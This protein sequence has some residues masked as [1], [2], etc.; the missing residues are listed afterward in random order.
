MTEPPEPEYD[1]GETLVVQH[2]EMAGPSALTQVLDARAATRPWRL[3]DVSAGAPFPDLD[4]VRGIVVLGGSMGVHDTADHP[5]LEGEIAG[6]RAALRRG[7][8][9][10]GICLGVQLLGAILGGEVRARGVPEIGF[11]PLERTA[12][13]RDD[14]VFAGWP[15]GA[16]TLFIHDDEVVRLPDGAVATLTGSDG[17]AAWRAPDGLSYGVQFHPEVDAAQVAAWCSEPRNRIRFE[18]AGVDPD[19]LAAEADRREPYVRA[20]GLALVGRWLDAVVGRDDP[21]PSRGRRARA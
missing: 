8:P 5:W 2:V 19:A 18:R 7:V 3:V 21:D 10:F 12:E 13:G 16:A 6:L 15:D 9:L 1:Y 14:P 20:V 4:D 17:V 11:V